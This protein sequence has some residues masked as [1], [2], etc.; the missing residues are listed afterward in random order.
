MPDSLRPDKSKVV[1][2]IEPTGKI[3]IASVDKNYPNAWQTGEMGKLLQNLAT[4]PDS[5]VGIIVGEERFPHPG[6]Y[7]GNGKVAGNTASLQ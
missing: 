5:K 6:I 1:L 7:N 2:W 3:L 4:L